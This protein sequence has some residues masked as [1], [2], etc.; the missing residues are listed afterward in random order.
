MHAYP[1]KK[2]AYFYTH[3]ATRFSFQIYIH[4]IYTYFTSI[5]SKSAY[6]TTYKYCNLTCEK[7]SSSFCFQ[8]FNVVANATFMYSFN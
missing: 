1:F 7:K 2:Y 5:F 3:S 6:V 4:G 8:P